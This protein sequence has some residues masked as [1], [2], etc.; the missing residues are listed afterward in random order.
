MQRRPLLA[1]R[2]HLVGCGFVDRAMGTAG[3][4]GHRTADPFLPGGDPAG[5]LRL[6]RMRGTGQRDLLRSQRKLRCGAGFDQG[7][8]LDRFQGRTRINQRTHIP[9]GQA[10]SA[11]GI[12]DGDGAA[13]YALDAVPSRDFDQN[14]IAHLA[15]FSVLALN[16][17]TGE[18]NRTGDRHAWLFRRGHGWS[19]QADES[20]QSAA[21]R[22]CVRRQFLLYH[23]GPRQADGCDIR[24]FRCRGASTRSTR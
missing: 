5:V 4:V 12:T 20:R 10:Q 16:M 15:A 2:D 22:A 1:A 14:G 24:H 19:F 18:R 8:G 23:R 17:V 3:E 13:M 7:N 11:I 6:T 21:H 9:D